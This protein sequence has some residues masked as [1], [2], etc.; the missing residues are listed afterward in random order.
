MKPCCIISFLTLIGSS[1]SLQAGVE[2]AVNLKIPPGT[3]A[4]LTAPG[5]K[6]ATFT[7]GP[8]STDDYG[9]GGFS[10]TNFIHTTNT[11]TLTVSNLPPHTTLEFGMHLSQMGSLDPARDGDLITITV[12]GIEVFHAGLG[13]G[14]AGG[15]HEDKI[16][17]FRLNGV[18]ASNALLETARTLTLDKPYDEHIYDLS[19]LAAL[20]SIVHT[21]TTATIVITASADQ[22]W[23][24]EGY[25]LDNIAVIL[26]AD[27]DGLSYVEETLLGTDP[28]KYDTDRDGMNDKSE[29]DNGLSPLI[30]NARK[31][32]DNDGLHDLI[33]VNRVGTDP[34]N[35]DTDGDG[36]PDLE[37]PQLELWNDIVFDHLQTPAHVTDIMAVAAGTHHILVA[38]TNGT[39][40]AWG[41]NSFGQSFVPSWV[42]STVEIST[43]LHGL[44]LQA[45]SSVVAWGYNNRGQATVPASVT[46]A[47]AVA[48]GGE[49]SLALLDDGTVAAWGDNS[50]GNQT[51]VPASVT[52]AIGIA[53]G[54]A[55]SLALLADG[56]VVAWGN[57]SYGQTNVP[58]SVTNA[59]AISCGD[60]HSLALLENT[61]IV[62]WGYNASGEST[63][64]P[65]IT[66]AVAIDA[67]G[68]HN[69]VLLEDG[70]VTAWGDN[71]SGQ[72]TQPASITIT[73]AVAISAGYSYST[74][75]DLK[76]N[77]LDPDSDNDG[78]EDGPEVNLYG[79]DP[80][81][82]DTDDDGMDDKAEVDNGLDP[83]ISNIGLDS[84][85]DQLSDISEVNTH[86]TNP[87]KA[88][89]DDDDIDDNAEIDNGL[90]PLVSNVGADSDGD[91]I[92]DKDEVDNGLNPL[93]S[94]T[95]QDSDNDNVD[96]RTEVQIGMN[97]LQ[98]DSIVLNAVQN[99]NALFGLYPSNV[100]LDLSV[101]QALFEIAAGTATLQLQLEQ[102]ED[103]QSWTN[104]GET[105]EW[106]LPVGT[107]KRF[108]R[109]RTGQ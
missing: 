40:A 5:W 9:D 64:P 59:I 56:S 65:G 1:I 94:N 17:F 53:A 55:H 96:D 33:E 103:L 29:V 84:D 10:S 83:L 78:L 41:D 91:Q 36:L 107:E 30:S 54:N 101:G 71:S 45:S 39:L 68:N 106:T 18:S 11:L 48:C 7:E 6:E 77:P 76:T 50:Y 86:G 25:G 98:D 75:L 19:Q 47:V 27:G 63:V 44:A 14:T 2:S 66:T 57:N 21:N 51:T 88:D 34:L 60:S 95:G 13:F 74:A 15:Y 99:N 93:V 105:V 80:N 32:S 37:S 58:A 82:A 102:S 69:L 85:N 23:G 20:K 46:N 109:V 62:A 52:N 49:F 35:P 73:N 89:T 16:Q 92:T 79:T 67:G 42:S 108:F 28:N 26:D 31:D 3:S 70:T 100:V 24:N 87:K 104:A 12:D 43:S 8:L 22:G 38:K 81:L 72:L 90:N 4:T 97:P 61:S